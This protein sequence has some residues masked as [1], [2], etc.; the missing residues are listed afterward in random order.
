MNYKRERLLESQPSEQS[1]IDDLPQVRIFSGQKHNFFHYIYFTHQK[2]KKCNENND[3][4]FFFCQFVLLQVR[5]ENEPIPLPNKSWDEVPSDQ[6]ETVV[7]IDSEVTNNMVT[8][9]TATT[10]SD[11]KQKEKKFLG[12]KYSTIATII[13]I[14]FL[15][16]FL[17]FM[18]R[19][20]QIHHPNMTD[21]TRRWLISMQKYLQN[22]YLW[23]LWVVIFILNDL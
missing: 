5:M 23:L 20:Y 22:T 9:E 18:I 10:V 21:Q 15:R 14:S 6:L 8:D 7:L 19:Q 16:L 1:S 2:I 11:Q 13:V 12:I 3:F 4:E 17:S